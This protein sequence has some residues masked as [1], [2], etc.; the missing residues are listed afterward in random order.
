MLRKILVIDDD[1]SV[2]EII[3]L[4]LESD[5]FK[6]VT[7]TD[8]PEGV[9]LAQ[10]E[11]PDLIFLDMSMPELNGLEVCAKLK[12]DLQTQ[13]IPVVMISA[14]TFKEDIRKGLEVGGEAYITKPFDPLTLRDVIGNVLKKGEKG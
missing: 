8:G 3:R 6:V 11:N 7:T 13:K 9:K 2:V 12:S 14:R 5:G 1:P 4:A 10:R